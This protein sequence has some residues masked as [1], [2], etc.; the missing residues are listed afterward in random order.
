M[1]ADGFD[2]RG[3]DHVKESIVYFRLGDSSETQGT[4]DV[5]AF[6]SR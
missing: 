4:T 6:I 2:F 5:G 1:M 3:I